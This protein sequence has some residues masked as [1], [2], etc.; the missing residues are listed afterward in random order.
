MINQLQFYSVIV[1]LGITPSVLAIS[2]ESTLEHD[3]AGTDNW[4][5]FRGPDHQGHSSE[6]GLP[7]HWSDS[8]NIARRTELPGQSWSSPIVWGNRV[9]VTTSG[10]WPK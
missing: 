3:G 4:P 2:L 9:F 5:Q 8:E 10:N 7:L 6:S 1:L